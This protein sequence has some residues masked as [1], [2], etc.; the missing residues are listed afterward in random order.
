MEKFLGFTLRTVRYGLFFSAFTP[1]VIFRAFWSPT[2]FGKVIVFRILIEII[3]G[4]WLVLAVYRSEYRPKMKSIGWILLS[5]V[6]SFFIS[7]I[8]G[9][10]PGRSFW[11][12]FERMG[13][14]FN[15]I[16]YFIYFVLLVSIFKTK[17]DWLAMLWF[18]LIAGFFSI[19]YGFLQLNQW[20]FILGYSGPAPR[21]RI[22]GTI[23]NPAMFGGYL[24]F[25]VFFCLLL[26]NNELSK[27]SRYKKYFL[28]GFFLLAIIALFLT[29]VRG[30]VLALL[31]GAGGLLI[32]TLFLNR[33]KLFDLGNKISKKFAMLI[34]VILAVLALIGW[35]A[36]TTRY[37]NRLSTFSLS[38]H[39]ILQ[40]LYVW[41]EAW[42]GFQEKP[43]LGWGSENFT[44]IHSKYFDPRM[45]YGIEGSIFDRPHNIM[46]ET[47]TDRG[48]LGFLI[49]ILAGYFVFRQL[50]K[51]YSNSPITILTLFF[52][53]TS[54]FIQGFFFFDTFAIYLMLAISLGLIE[55]GVFFGE[56]YSN[57]LPETNHSAGNLVKPKYASVLFLFIPVSL[58]FLIYRFS[59][60]PIIANNLS[61][62]AAINLSNNNYDAGV[63]Q[64]KKSLDYSL[65]ESY[66]YDIRRNVE[67]V[68]ADAVYK[69][70]N[71]INKE[72]LK[73]DLEYLI[74]E[75]GKD[76][77][78]RINEAESYTG[79][80][81]LYLIYANFLSSDKV[82]DSISILKK[83]TIE[84]PSVVFLWQELA[85]AYGL[86]GDYLKMA[87]SLNKAQDLK[88]DWFN[89]QFMRGKALITG[90]NEK[91]GLAVALDAFQKGYNNIDDAIWISSYLKQKKQNQKMLEFLSSMAA[92]DPNY[93]VYLAVAYY[94]YGDR[95]QAK[96][97]A[98]QALAFEKGGEVSSE[99]FKLLAELYRQLKDIKNR[100]RA[101]EKAGVLTPL[102]NG[103][104]E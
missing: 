61:A 87:E 84:A 97:T 18:T 13:G 10:D 98:D 41:R 95:L 52:L 85:N 3:F 24:L 6:I 99:S 33:K 37:F 92:K 50:K 48:A 96:K 79:L 56:K 2:N 20:N 43:L 29:A 16:H 67:P 25:L 62:K 101:F 93:Y 54:Y 76:P 75:F 94:N 47:L 17:K 5:L 31:I 103:V 88:P 100:T 7:G 60:L 77:K 23:G 70:G 49:L 42:R 26:F 8:F 65:P 72:D 28:A 32:T 80:S 11:G 44:A 89:L 104:S 45:Y 63:S 57:Q 9:I 58:I 90:G 69:M 22:F 30:A 53:F 55:S 64:W 34:L 46:L 73:N 102:D 19:I 86:K 12:G 4:L 83:G 68:Y 59:I 14:T 66:K 91:E 39:N 35:F 38:D 71:A 15:L 27:N 81:G 1:L 21:S 40:R 78:T 82:N 51:N 36:S 74:Q